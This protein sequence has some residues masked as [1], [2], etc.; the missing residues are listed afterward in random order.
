VDHFF[1][2]G[3]LNAEHYRAHGV[4]DSN[5]TFCRY[6]VVDRFKGSLEE[7]AARG[8]TKRAE[9]GVPEGVQLVMFS[10]KLIPKKTPLVLIE[11]LERMPLE[12]RG[13]FALLYVGAGEQEQM[14]K[15]RAKSLGTQ[16]VFAG[17]VNQG[18]IADFY[19]AADA[20]ILPSQ[21][22]GETWG[23]VANEAMMAGKPVILSRHAGSSRD[24]AGFAGV[25]VVEPE[26]GA[27]EEA[28]RVLP[29][30]VRGESVRAQMESYS[31][32][33]AARAIASKVS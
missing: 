12:E 14:L 13:K 10:G 8:A 31:V 17:F 5:M 18:S 30:Q 26:A 25:Q 1:P 28:L 24:F 22:M 3:N 27:V 6:C 7:L 20:L 11:A 9:L 32:E 4:A 23:L 21:Q 29:S 2:I 16:V 19:L 15:D 33:T